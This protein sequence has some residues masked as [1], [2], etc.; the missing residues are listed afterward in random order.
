MF[1]NA[2]QVSS[3]DRQEAV[4]VSR[5]FQGKVAM[6]PGVVFN[7]IRYAVHDGP[8]IRVTVFLK[9]CP[10]RCWWCHN[11]EG[12]RV[13]PRPMLEKDDHGSAWGGCMS[14]DECDANRGA[15]MTVGE[16]L[17]EIEKETVFMDESGGGATFS[18]G[19]PLMQAEF[20]NALL[21]ACR[22]R[23]IHTAVDTSGF[24]DAS[25]FR[26]AAARADLF[27]YDLK[28]MD[29][30]AHRQYVGVPVGPVLENLRWLAEQRSTNGEL[31]VAKE[32]APGNGQ[33]ADFVIRVPVIPGI[34]D[35]EANLEAMG[36][37]LQGL[38]RPIRMNLLPYHQTAAHKYERLKM[39]NRMAGIEPPTKEH[40]NELKARFE[41]LGF[42]VGIGG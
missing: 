1:D 29:D 25:V 4:R 2:I 39:E 36:E 12:M 24:A 17:T 20:L 23:D 32:E 10:L 5:E 41:R 31:R 7:I 18:G 9:G 19:E 42:E 26:A 22:A 40:M 37:F 16:V 27:L 3:R 14:G 33:V 11:P 8:G 28:L 35:T 21:E 34:T 13:D 30:E 38:G 15:V 6:T